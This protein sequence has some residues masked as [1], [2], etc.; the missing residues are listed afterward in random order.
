MRYSFALLTFSLLLRR[1]HVGMF[2]F[3]VDPERS[4]GAVPSIAPVDGT[5]VFF[6]DLI[7]R[8]PILLFLELTH[9]R[10]YCI[11]KRLCPL[12]RKPTST[13]NSCIWLNS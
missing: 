8:P 2:F 10:P 5:D 11:S 4:L 1:I 13:P 7:C 9:L 6:D 3:D 12:L